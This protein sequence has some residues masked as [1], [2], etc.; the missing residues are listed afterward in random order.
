MA[1][2]ELCA[3]R[4]CENCVFFCGVVCLHTSG[5]QLTP[6]W[7]FCVPEAQDGAVVDVVSIQSIEDIKWTLSA[8]VATPL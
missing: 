3:F 8:L 2:K 5:G 1:V 4:P 7:E 6:G